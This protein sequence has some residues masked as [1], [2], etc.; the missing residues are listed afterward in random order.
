MA[1][2]K[3]WPSFFHKWNCWFEPALITLGFQLPPC[4]WPL[5][6]LYSL[7]LLRCLQLILRAAV[8]FDSQRCGGT[9]TQ[10]VWSLITPWKADLCGWVSASSVAAVTQLLLLTLWQAAFMARWDCSSQDLNEFKLLWNRT[11]KLW[12]CVCFQL[13]LLVWVTALTPSPFFFFSF[14]WVRSNPTV[15]SANLTV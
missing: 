13:A 15:R 2:L 10:P 12:F 6:I 8:S 7:N 1:L 9:E 5:Q 11:L 14:G 3:T 4:C